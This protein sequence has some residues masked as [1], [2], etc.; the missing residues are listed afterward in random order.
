MNSANRHVAGEL[1]S[2]QLLVML[3]MFADRVDAIVVEV[4]VMSVVLVLTNGVDEL[5]VGNVEVTLFSM[6]NF[7]KTEG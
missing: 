3:V 7:T 2:R 4:V 1:F 5:V 6:M